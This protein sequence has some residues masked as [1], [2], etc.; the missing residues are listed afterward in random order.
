MSVLLE[1]LRALLNM[2]SSL[3]NGLIV[4]SLH[5]ILNLLDGLDDVDLLLDHTI[6]SVKG[7]FIPS[8]WLAIIEAA[9]VILVIGI[10]IKRRVF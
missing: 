1:P 9:L 6:D 3:I 10:I 2:I 7:F 4:G 8:E 5:F